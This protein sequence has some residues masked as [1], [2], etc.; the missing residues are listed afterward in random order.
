MRL[1]NVIKKYDLTKLLQEIKLIP[2]KLN[3][4]IIGEYNNCYELEIPSFSMLSFWL[5]EKSVVNYYLLKEI[6][7]QE[8]QCT[9]DGHKD[10]SIKIEIMLNEYKIPFTKNIGDH[11]LYLHIPKAY[12]NISD[13]NNLTKNN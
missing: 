1:I 6:N 2:K 10:E 13:P 4:I 12:F 7:N 11:I 3:A 9:F 5:G 8:V